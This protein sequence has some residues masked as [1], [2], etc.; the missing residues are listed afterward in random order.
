[1]S[2][3]DKER[4]GEI[5]RQKEGERAIMKERAPVGKDREI[6]KDR[7][8]AGWKA[9]RKKENQITDS[10]L[11]DQGERPRGREREGWREREGERDRG[12]E[13]LSE[14]GG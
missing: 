7:R 5:H 6:G 11:G 4:D 3:M 2:Q 10:N 13:R 8:K 9:G 1:M 14:R 12:M